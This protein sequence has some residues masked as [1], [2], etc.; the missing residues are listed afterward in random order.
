MPIEIR[1]DPQPTEPGAYRIPEAAY[2]ADPCPS[3]SLSSTMA[4]ILLDASPLHAWA[5]HPRFNSAWRPQ[6]P[7]SAQLWGSVIHNLLLED[8]K[9]VVMLPFRDYRKKE[10]QRARDTA[11]RQNLLPLLL[12]QAQAVANMVDAARAQMPSEIDVREGDAEVS[13]VVDSGSSWRRI[14]LDW[15]SRSRELFVDYKTTSGLASEAAFKRQAANLGY[16]IQ[17]AFYRRVLGQTFPEL[18][19]RIRC[20]FLV[21]ENNFPHALATYEL[22]EADLTV[23][24]RKVF[25]AERIWEG[26]LESDRWPG[27]PRRPVRITM[28]EWNTRQWIDREL[29]E[30]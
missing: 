13:V 12:D 17:A 9:R 28:P 29:A 30:E 19:G 16:D 11:F 27:Y 24:E 3:P 15:W 8:G 23:A 10:S 21:Q 22:S 4:R 7:T 18:A 20:L 6:P 25:E 5:A 1:D 14:R 26:C 2:H